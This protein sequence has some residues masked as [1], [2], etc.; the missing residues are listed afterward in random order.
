MAAT[1]YDLAEKA[2]VS[3]STV[4]KALND[5]YSISEKTKQRIR[6]IADSIGYKPNARARSFARR[7]NGIILFAADLS[8]G[9]GF[10]NPHMFEIVTGVDRYLEE[11]GYSLILKHVAK[12]NAPE[13]VKEL[14]LSEEA[15]G[16]IIHAGI[17]SK[18]LAFVLGKEQY[19]HLLIGKPDFSSALSWIDVS[20]ESAGQI[21]ANYLLDKGYRRIVF[22]MGNA[23]EDQISLRRLDGINMVFEE[24]ELTIETITGITNFEESRI[25]TERILKRD[26]IPE[27][28]LCTNNYLA[29]GCLQ[30]I[31]AKQLRIPEDIAIMT[32]DNYPF[33]MLTVP[34]L[35]AIEVDMYDMGNQAARFM[36]QKI[37][38]PNLQT[39]SFC[40]TPLL[41]EREST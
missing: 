5:S 4:S 6:E 15:D 22:L 19:P 1:I 30:S 33:S 24:E 23:K 11:K 7:K 9:V 28:I 29:M 38:K 34:T 25:V 16:I 31:R 17:L 27:V 32:F 14:M 10:E 26:K 2:G 8:R 18:Q 36:L 39:Q 40:T 20:H 21:A 37:K 13:A 3:I 41:L 12:D 35:T